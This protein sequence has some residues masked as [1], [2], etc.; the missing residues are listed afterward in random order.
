MSTPWAKSSRGARAR[1]RDPERMRLPAK[2]THA[3]TRQHNHRLVLRTVYDF[4]PISRA[5]VAR[6]TGLTRTTVGDVV[7]ALLDEGMVEEVGRGPSTGGKSPI[8]LSLVGDA[9]QVIGLDLGESVF[10]GALVNL[11]GDVRRVVELPVE[12]RNG[13]AALELVFRLVDELLGEST[14]APLGIGVGTPGLVDTRTGTIRWAVNLDWQDLPLGGLLHERYG[15]PSNVAND[16][17]AAALAE[18]TFG[19]EG[20]RV[21][22]LVT[23]KVGR[24]IGAGL[25]LNGS[26]FQGDGFGAG[27]IGHVAVVDDGAACRCGR[28][29]CLE[30]VASSRAIATRA[31][32][33][34][35]ELGTPLA[36]LAARRGHGELTIDDLVRAWLDGDPAARQAALEAARYLGRA[37]AALIG[38]LNVGRVVLDGPVTGFG[39]EWLAAVAD[40]ARRRSLPLLSGDTEIEFGRLSENVVV[41]GASAL[42]ITRELG[43]SLAR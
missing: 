20:R 4:G 36:A 17:Q 22:N 10:S 15:L 19:A 23:I 27:E 12:G 24:G 33:L 37:I 43:L 5:D 35:T 21:L 8:L 34:A 38:A 2:A 11:R 3:Q 7:G 9:R 26:L 40:E 25:V 28:F 42:L 1:T 18:Y 31:A 6:S 14:T 41:L 30:T 16:S 32:E 39:D 29:G 13:R